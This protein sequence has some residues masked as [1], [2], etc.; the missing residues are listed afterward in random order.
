[1][2]KI[3]EAV[4]QVY[5]FIPSNVDAALIEVLD[6]KLIRAESAAGTVTASPI[7]IAPDIIKYRRSHYFLAENAFPMDIFD[8]QRVKEAFRSGI[9]VTATFALMLP[10]RLYRFSSA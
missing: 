2:N 4:F 8:F 1:M 7:V 3:C 9:I 6:F 10:C 5:G